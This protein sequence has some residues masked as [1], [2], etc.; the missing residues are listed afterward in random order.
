MA[1]GKT[2][3]VYTV[4]LAKVHEPTLDKYLVKLGLT[5]K[6]DLVGKTKRLVERQKEMGTK[7]EI[8]PENMAKCDNCGGC[9]DI[10]YDECPYCGDAGMVDE[11][12]VVTAA[13]ASS[14]EPEPAP[15]PPPK[16]RSEVGKTTGGKGK[17]ASGKK[18]AA[19]KAAKG[20]GGSKGKKAAKGKPAAPT[21]EA[22]GKVVEDGSAEL[23]PAYTEKDL[24]KAVER[25]AEAAVDTAIG[26][27][28]YGQEL[29]EVHSKELWK[30]R[31]DK[32]GGPRHKSFDQFCRDEVKVSRQHAY[33][34]MAVATNYTK[35]QL[36]QFG[37]SKLH[38]ALEVP[39]ELRDK[40][41]GDGSESKRELSKRARELAGKEEAAR[42][43]PKVDK[44]KA[45][46][47]AIVPGIQ[48]LVMQKRPVKVPW[49]LGKPTE[50]AKSLQDDPWFRL[51]LT[52]DVVL[53]VRLTRNDKGEIIAIVEHRRGQETS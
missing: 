31:L 27:Y 36:E 39:P 40:L 7:G 48:E 17:K 34:L 24:N 52:N 14:P 23:L 5:S 29:A 26:I 11:E 47:V 41:L 42:H 50:P 8:K 37:I 32:D 33:R 3:K 20:K 44:N 28:N 6:G 30:L 49:P 19:K 38:V 46:T 43:T 10:D 1:E 12:E 35:A 9:S 4:E 25:I 51:P 13:A 15:P 53:S 16:K 22:V 21:P 2:E 18:P 45:V